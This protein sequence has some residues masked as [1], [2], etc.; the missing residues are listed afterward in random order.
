MRMLGLALLLGFLALSTRAAAAEP[1]FDRTWSGNHA[2]TIPRGRVE[3]GLFQSSHYG[4]TDRLELSLH[5]IVFF[6][7]PHVEAKVLAQQHGR[8]AWGVRGRLAYP[9]LFL[10]LISRSGALGLLPETSSPR[11]RWSRCGYTAAR[12]RAA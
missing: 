10:G 3:L 1:S 2:S 9:T 11:V 7:L 5:P 12:T 8:L 6:A 4:V